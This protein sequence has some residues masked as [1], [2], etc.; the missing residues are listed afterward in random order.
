MAPSEF[1]I[2]R[3]WSGTCPDGD[4]KDYFVNGMAHRI[5]ED[6]HESAIQGYPAELVEDFV[7]RCDKIFEESSPDTYEQAQQLIDSTDTTDLYDLVGEE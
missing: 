4:L 3:A 6:S 7:A 5:T 1:P 2:R